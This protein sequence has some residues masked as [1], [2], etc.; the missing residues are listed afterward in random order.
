VVGAFVGIVVGGF[1]A[2]LLELLP[3]MVAAALSVGAGVLLTGAF[4]EDALGDVADSMGGRDRSDVVRILKDPRQGT[5]GVMALVVAFT[6]RVAALSGMDAWTALAIVPCA[7]A[8]ARGA[9]VLIMRGP[10]AGEGLGATFASSV[11]G[12]DVA[13]A[14]V[15]TLAIGGLLTGAWVV[16]AVVLAV[17]MAAVI[18]RLAM[19]TVGGVSGDFLGAAEQLGEMAVFVLGAAIV[20]NGWPVAAWWH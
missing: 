5:Y 1:Y 13:F 16:A 11:R 8:A 3:P 4:H 9:S 2:V 19:I 12:R 14:S 17:L 20:H 6:V 15:A 18:A 7:H 10:V